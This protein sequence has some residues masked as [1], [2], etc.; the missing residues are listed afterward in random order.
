M[1]KDLIVDRSSFDRIIS[2]GGYVSVDT[3]NAQ[4]A[5]AIHIAK[6]DADAAFAA[7]TCIGCGACVASCKNA[8]AMLFV[9]AKVTHLA[10]LPQGSVERPE[11]VENMVAQMDAE[12]FGSCTNT[13][14]CSASC[15][16]GISLI[17]IALMNRE[18]LKSTLFKKE[19]AQGD[20]V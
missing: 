18:L 19:A 14:S 12:G 17:N 9:A 13:G 3:G 7:A 4:D 2:S 5:N 11:R 8:S 15:P 16:K 6:P 1:I 20:G 10:L